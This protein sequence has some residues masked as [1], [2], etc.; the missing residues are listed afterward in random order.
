[1]KGDFVGLNPS[2]SSLIC[3]HQQFFDDY[4][5]MGEASVRIA[6]K[7][8]K[9]LVDYGNASGQIINWR[10]SVMYFINVSEARQ[11]K[12]KK[13]IG[14]EIGSLP[15]S[16]LRLPLGLNPPDSFWNLLIVKFT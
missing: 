6:R 16:Y 10:K 12:I 14:C 15:G 5:V 1:M 2:S 9:S 8:K 13:V 7:I 11:N 3:S 4:I